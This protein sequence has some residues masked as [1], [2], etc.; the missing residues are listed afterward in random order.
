MKNLENMK[1]LNEMELAMVAGG[2]NDTSI[3]NVFLDWLIQLPTE[4]SIKAPC[5]RG[6][7]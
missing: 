2:D 7:C 6:K 1:A 5:K 3:R 4:V